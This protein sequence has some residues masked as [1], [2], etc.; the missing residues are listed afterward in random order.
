MSIL[1]DSKKYC[2]PSLFLVDL[3]N[4]GDCM[5][6]VLVT[7]A[8]GFIGSSLMESFSNK[9]YDVEGWDIVDEVRDGYRV[10]NVDLS[11]AEV[12]LERLKVAQPDIVIH[13][14]G[15]ADVGKSVH[16]PSSDYQGNVTLTHNLMFALHKLHMKTTRFVFL[17]S[18]AVYGNPSSLPITENSPLNPLSPYALHKVM[19]EDI[20]S[21]F[22]KNYGMDIKVARIFSA[23]GAGLKKQI[24]WD[25]YQKSQSTG[26]LEMFGTGRES[27]DYIHVDDVINAIHLIATNPIGDNMIFN[28]ANG[29]EVT[30][31]EATE[32]FASCAEIPL[33]K[34]NFNGVVR[35][36][37]P[38]N[39]RADTSRL[40]S[41]GY[42]K[43]MEMREGLHSYY[44]EIHKN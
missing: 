19:C 36:G 9:G 7:G 17:S 35:E 28:V 2:K 6:K 23:Y 29:E 8:N 32:L 4:R 38:L 15:S 21:Y 44:K 37:E 42:I 39:W 10:F 3:R 11:K 22:V 1:R 18:A 5:K 13:C 12:L 25:M 43:T 34:I 30:I 41:L 33:D 40:K 14:A 31:R 20:C 24:F 16:N 26:K 27:R